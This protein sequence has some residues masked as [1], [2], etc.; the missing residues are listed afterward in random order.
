MEEESRK[1]K[2]IGFT[3]SAFDL[4]HPGHVLMLQ[5]CKD[6]CD[7]L[8]VGLHVDPSRERSLKNKPTQSVT[9]RFIQ[10]QG[11]KYVDEIIPYETETDLH[12]LLKT[13]PIKVRILGEEKATTDFSG[14][15][16]CASLG[17]H[18]YFNRRLH[19]YS[20]SA[21]RERIKACRIRKN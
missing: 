7:Y 17:I 2:Y 1:G 3:A 4:L 16:I 15:S 11:C 10:L 18:I 21:L 19:N 13:L 12:N 9:E 6:V 20:S 14:K 5:E 8:I